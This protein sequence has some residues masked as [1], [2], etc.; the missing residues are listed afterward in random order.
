MGRNDRRWNICLGKKRGDCVGKT[1]RGKGTKIM[2]LVAADG[3]IV[4][5]IVNALLDPRI[6]Y[7]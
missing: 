4:A 3:R 6:K 2:L 1:K 5:D 7:T